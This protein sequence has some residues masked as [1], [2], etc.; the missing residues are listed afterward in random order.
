MPS[1]HRRFPGW[2]SHDPDS[3]D[4]EPCVLTMHY[5]TA[6]PLE[7][8]L[9]LPIQQYAPGYDGPGTYARWH[10]CRFQMAA[11]THV[12]F[13]KFGI[14]DVQ[15]GLVQNWLVLLRRGPLRVL[16]GTDV[17]LVKRFLDDVER[18]CPVATTFDLDVDPWIEQ[19][20]GTNA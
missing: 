19:L 13:G 7:V 17:D 2:L 12:R 14:G 1:I 16:V 20:L 11:S 3:N 10:F 9:R 15:V 8:R 4:R 6:A 18:L 5:T